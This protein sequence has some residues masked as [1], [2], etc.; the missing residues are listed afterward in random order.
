MVYN[1]YNRDFGLR[2]GDTYVT[3]YQ[4]GAALVFG[5]VLTFES[6]HDK[7]SFGD[8]G[9]FKDI[10]E[11][12][13]FI[14]NFTKENDI[15]GTLILAAFQLGGDPHQLDEQLGLAKSEKGNYYEVKC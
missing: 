13:A 3:E 10:V 4:E 6:L 9:D 12:L 5:A 14:R 11:L 7:T 2:C 15:H 1:Q 8:F